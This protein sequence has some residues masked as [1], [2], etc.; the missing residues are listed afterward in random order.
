MER[1][2]RLSDD[3]VSEKLDDK[4]GKMMS[5]VRIGLDTGMIMSGKPQRTK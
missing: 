1:A 3:R 5:E 4:T 2:E